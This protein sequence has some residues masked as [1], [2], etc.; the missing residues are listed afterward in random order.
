MMKHIK[1]AILMMCVL[2]LLMTSGCLFIPDEEEV[3]V[4]QIKEPRKVK[5]PTVKAIRGD[6]KKVVKVIAYVRANRQ[7]ELSFVH[8]SGFLTVVHKEYGDEVKKGEIL[9]ELD[10]EMIKIDIKKQKVICVDAKASYESLLNNQNIQLESAK[11]ELTKLQE[12]HEIMLKM[13]DSYAVSEINSKEDQ[14]KSQEM[15]IVQLEQDKADRLRSA[16]K[17]LDLANIQLEELNTA[18]ASA[19]IFA[20]Y[21]GV[22]TYVTDLK[23]GE[24]VQIRETVITVADVSGTRLEYKGSKYPDFIK[25]QVIEVTIDEGIYSGKVISTGD[26]VPK[27][28]YERFRERVIFDLDEW[29]ENIT[30]NKPV[31]AISILASSTDTI[32]VPKGAVTDYKGRRFV[33][34]LQGDVVVEK[35]VEIGIHNDTQYEILN[36]LEEGEEI[37][38]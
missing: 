35:D 3:L 18:L 16:K 34:V 13:K 10:T 1:R 27:E 28:D 17:N 4:P 29:P 30:L 32:L 9:A 8:R 33:K 24:K 15:K 11:K 5:Y 2:S 19:V 12:Q 36:G 7:E 25:G 31:K 22:V 23:S 21:D 26:D 6:I 38:R 14:I 37:I 20:P